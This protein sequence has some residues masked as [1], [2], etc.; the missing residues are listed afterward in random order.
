MLLFTAC[1]DVS[2]EAEES[3][4]EAITNASVDIADTAVIAIFVDGLL[5]CTGTM[6]SQR[7]AITA[8]HCVVKYHAMSAHFGVDARAPDLVIP[9]TEA[10]AHPSFDPV[11]LDNDIAILL[12]AFPAHGITPKLLA[13]A[14]EA[15]RMDEQLRVVGFGRTGP[16]VGGPTAGTRRAGNATLSGVSTRQVTIAGTP[17]QPCSGDS[18]GPAITSDESGER[19][20]AVTSKGDPDCVTG[21]VATRVSAYASFLAPWLASP[22]VSG[23]NS[24]SL[25]SRASNQVSFI[26]ILV[27]GIVLRR[28]RNVHKLFQYASN[29]VAE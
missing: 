1:C 21:A 22:S 24:S 7:V 17:S 5:D 4:N 13:T 11:T 16:V 27:A 2:R 26:V 18:G 12:L 25:A 6:I 19:I 23:C 15:L 9:I 8:A 3:T 20:V 29:Q 28:N 14:D 10:H